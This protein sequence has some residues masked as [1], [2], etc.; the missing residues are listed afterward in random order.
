MPLDISNVETEK[1][2]EKSSN[3][4]KTN[5]AGIFASDHI[6]RFISFHNLIREKGATFPFLIVNTDRSDKSGMH[7]WSI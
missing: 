6:N 7:W 5:F 3:E 2:F 1:F 4:L